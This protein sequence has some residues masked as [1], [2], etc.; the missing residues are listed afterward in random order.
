MKSIYRAFL[1]ITFLLLFNSACASKAQPAPTE[2]WTQL[3]CMP[4][5]ISENGAF[6]LDDRNESDMELST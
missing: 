5:A 1:S 3:A 2:E 4:T 6:M